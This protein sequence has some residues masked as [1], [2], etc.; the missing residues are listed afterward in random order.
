[1][2]SLLLL[3]G[4]ASVTPGSAPAIEGADKYLGAVQAFAARALDHGR[5]THGPKNTPL[6]VDGL[7][8][9]T[10]EPPVY[11]RDGEEWVLA[12]LANQQNLIR[13]LQSL[14]LLTGDARYRKAA[15]D[16]IRFAF[17]HL[18]EPG[19]LLWWGGH[20]AYDARG[21][22]WVSEAKQHELKFH[23]PYYELMWDVDPAATRRFVECFWQAHVQSWDNLNMNRHGFDCDPTGVWDREYRGG[24]VPCDGA[25]SFINTGTD[26]IYSAGLL[27]HFT[28]DDAPLVWSKRLAQRYVDIQHPETGLGGYQ[29][30]LTEKRRV[31]V[32]F[33]QYGGEL[34][35][36]TIIST[37]GSAR[38]DRS[39]IVKL[40][41]SEVLGDRGTDYRD[42]ALHDLR[43]YAK[44]GY[45]PAT[46]TMY[47]LHYN[48][49]R[50]GPD[51]IKGPGYFGPSRIAPRPPAPMHLY[52]YAMGYR[53]GGHDDL[54]RTVRAMGKGFGL[55][56]LGEKPG[57]A[58][59]LRLDTSCAEPEVI[60]AMLELHRAT[61]CDAYLDVAAAV[62]DNVLATR[63]NNGL[64]VP[65]KQHRFT[66]LNDPAPLALLHL[67]AALKGTG[68]ALPRYLCSHAYFTC[69]Y[70]G[71]GRVSD[72]AVIY[73]LLRE[74]E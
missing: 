1:M 71:R 15:A 31:A 41:L 56:D 21:D 24:K 8:V 4:T 40:H 7:D 65:S 61:G 22:R 66:R 32:Q 42:W 55:G 35:E 18:R 2:L 25:L 73:D 70:D 67:C 27:S 59:A 36:A 13:V 11:I 39:A 60:F 19:G 72:G 28:G 33:P 44:Y 20:R 6:F 10:L 45:D 57:Q 17:D 34:N 63:V 58:P 43:T 50:I 9:D 26:L 53:I 47:A 46:N 14:T 68:T 16:A 51:D 74:A 64:F 48:G 54:W 62:A 52:A 23:L 29:F 38:S 5:D 37:G 49:A 30:T 3:S 69:P 12:N